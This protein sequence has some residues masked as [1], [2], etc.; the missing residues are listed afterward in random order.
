M[1]DFDSGEI[2]ESARPDPQYVGFDLDAVLTAVVGLRAEVPEDAFTAEVLG[3]ERFGS[4][5]VI[6]DD[7]L[8]LTIGYLVTEA[9]RVW[10][11]TNSGVAAPAHV[12]AYD[13]VT[14][15]GLVQALSRLDVSSVQIAAARGIQVGSQ[16]IAASVGGRE[17]ALQTRLAAKREFAGYW[18]YLLEEAL[19]TVPAHPRWSGAAMLDEQ[20]KLIGVG[21][22][23]VQTT[24]AK[25]V[26]QSGNMFVPADL[27]PP[28]LDDLLRFGRATREPRPWLGFYPAETE[29]GVEITALAPQGPAETSGIDA[30]DVIVEVAG[31][32]IDDLADL[33]RKM[34]DLGPA[35]TEVPLTV[36]RDGRPVQLTVVSADRESFLKRPALH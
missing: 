3:T 17:Q 28:I 26:Q 6:S 24:S 33:Y 34:W 7:G 2:P 22:L 25:G 30:G 35:G 11:T 9:E 36:L 8:V 19:F 5:V 31:L 20:G 12:V 23:L 16:V 4:G 15:F 13:Q 1:T 14:G 21:S 32:R 18:E 10:L 29:S 27:L